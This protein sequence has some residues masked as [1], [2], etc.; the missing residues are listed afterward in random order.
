MLLDRQD[1]DEVQWNTFVENS[2]QGYIYHY[3]WYLDAVCPNWKAIIVKNSQ[4]W[5]AVMPLNIQKKWGISYIFQ[6]MLTQF[7]GILFTPQN[8]SKPVKYLSDKKEWVNEIIARIP[9]KV[10]IFNYNFSPYFDYPL[11]FYWKKYTLL[12]RYNYELDLTQGIDKIIENLQPRTRRYIRQVEREQEI[13]VQNS[14]DIE[15]FIVEQKKNQRKF[16]NDRLSSI[17]AVLYQKAYTQGRAILLTAH[18]KDKMLTGTLFMQHKESW[19]SL[20][21]SLKNHSESQTKATEILLWKAI[22]IATENG[23]KRFDF[24]GSMIE[25]VEHFCRKFGGKPVPYL[26]I[27]KYGIPFLK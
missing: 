6:P 5:L 26:N 9:D 19:I 24:E 13:I 11:P 21:G 25:G 18:S 4:E 27:Q 15:K 12:T 3:T 14:T 2:P 7:L 23:A 8:D 16:I 20:Y 17:V 1:I 22:K 10:K